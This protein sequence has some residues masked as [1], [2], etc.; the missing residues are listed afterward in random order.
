MC[1]EKFESNHQHSTASENGDTAVVNGQSSAHNHHNSSSNHEAVANTTAD[2]PM[3]IRPHRL[4]NGQISPVSTDSGV[5]VGDLSTP[6]TPAS[7]PDYTAIKSA[8]KEIN[9]N[10]KSPPQE[11]STS[12]SGSAGRGPTPSQIPMDT[13]DIVVIQ[14]T[15]FTVKVVA[16]GCDPFELQVTLSITALMIF[17]M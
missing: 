13:D 1:E 9:N 10:D 11:K 14:D 5:H 17:S 8:E 2:E 15:S 16:P 7:T 6:L 12:T 4:T 3:L